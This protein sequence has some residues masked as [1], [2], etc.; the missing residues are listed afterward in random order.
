MRQ[1]H[2]NGWQECRRT[3]GLTHSLL[4]GAVDVVFELDADLPLV[5]QVSDERVLEQLLRA[6][7]LAV[8]LHQAALD[9]RLELLRPVHTYST[10]P[11]LGIGT[12]GSGGPPKCP[13]CPT[14]HDAMQKSHISKKKKTTR[15]LQK[16]D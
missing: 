2:F 3:D 4:L 5:G 13:D 7:P 8:A 15:I 10:G 9:E 16:N 1:S 12:G 14:K 6:G 11:D